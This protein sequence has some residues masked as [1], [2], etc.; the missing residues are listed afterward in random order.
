MAVINPDHFSEKVHCRNTPGM[1]KEMQM[2][3]W[4]MKVVNVW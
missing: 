4:K 1:S 2:L 3:S